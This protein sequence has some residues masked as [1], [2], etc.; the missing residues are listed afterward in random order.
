MAKK[1]NE[2]SKRD[3]FEK[4]DTPLARNLSN[5]IGRDVSKMA[6][7]LNCSPQAI[8]QYKQG[9]AVPQ[10]EKLIKIARYFNVSTDYLLGLSNVKSTDTELKGVCEYTGLSEETIGKLHERAEFDKKYPQ[11]TNGLEHLDAFIENYGLYIFDYLSEYIESVSLCGALKREYSNADFTPRGLVINM[12]KGEV[13][14]KA[15][16]EDEKRAVECYDKE[17]KEKQPLYLYN[18]QKMFIE[19][20]EKYG[21]AKEEQATMKEIA[22]RRKMHS[23]SVQKYNDE[24]KTSLED[25]KNTFERIAEQREM[26]FDFVQR[27]G[28]FTENVLNKIKDGAEN[29]EHT[30]KTK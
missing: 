19:F 1:A 18:L 17:I 14:R 28:I 30:G 21:E 25:V 29:G 15:F 13:K 8:N 5:L 12:K 24:L 7:Y 20:A 22:E 10:V 16:S 2:N 3:V 4:A 11:Y 6:E 9:T 27:S 26:Y 23:D